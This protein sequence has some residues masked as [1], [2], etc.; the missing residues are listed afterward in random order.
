MKR[1]EMSRAMC[2]YAAYLCIVCAV[3]SCRNGDG[4]GETY[5]S[6]SNDC[7]RATNVVGTFAIVKEPHAQTQVERLE[8]DC[9]R[10]VGKT[11]LAPEEHSM[12]DVILGLCK[13]I[14]KLPKDDA[15][16]LF[17]RWIDMA[18]EQPV[19]NANHT[20]RARLFEQAFDIVFFAINSSLDMRTDHFEHWDKVF[21]FYDKCTKEIMTM[22]KN[23]ECQGWPQHSPSYMYLRLFRG[24]VKNWVYRIRTVFFD[25]YSNGLTEE[26]KA[27]V[28]RRFDELK[29][30]IDTPTTPPNFHGGQK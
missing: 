9:R 12:Y 17:D 8:A 5:S 20:I 4:A 21:R 29:K 19:T 23:L 13:E 3:A 10:L 2:Q 18:I 14:R 15:L 28:I 1:M 6:A 30:Y 7:K 26:Q 22:E 27:D 11:H 16:P 24:D 25:V